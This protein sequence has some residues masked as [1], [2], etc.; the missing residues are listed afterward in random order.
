MTTP[1][2]DVNTFDEFNHPQIDVLHSIQE[3]SVFKGMR[4]DYRY[5][6]CI[7]FDLKRNLGEAGEIENDFAQIEKRART[8]ES[9]NI[10][11]AML[12]E[13]IEVDFLRLKF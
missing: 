10:N 7:K 12:E 13:E 8:I 4:F 9:R 1:E 3:E 2:K 11:Q 5:S 6:N